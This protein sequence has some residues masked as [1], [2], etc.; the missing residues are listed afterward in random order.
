VISIGASSRS[1]ESAE[2]PL[3]FGDA[4][5]LHWNIQN[6][7]RQN[8]LID[9][10]RD[11]S[12]VLH[13]EFESEIPII[14]Y[15]IGQSA[16]SFECNV[17]GNPSTVIAYQCFPQGIISHDQNKGIANRRDDQKES[18]YGQPFSEAGNWI[19]LPKPPPWLWQLLLSASCLLGFLA[20]ILLPN[21]QP[22]PALPNVA[23]ATLYFLAI[24][25][26]LL[27]IPA[28]YLMN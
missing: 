6:K 11:V 10:R 7:L 22:A 2:S 20:L 26:A 1:I 23:S 14:V 12:Y 13:R 5:A 15:V 3:G 4:L 9:V 17:N 28:A 19:A 21:T 25:L 8:R 16:V 18:V 24:G 27:S